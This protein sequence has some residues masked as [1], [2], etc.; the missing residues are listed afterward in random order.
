MAK[1]KPSL[2][3]RTPYS[4]PSEGRTTKTGR[5]ATKGRASKTRRVATKGRATNTGRVAK[6]GRRKETR[7]TGPYSP[8]FLQHLLDHSV[9]PAFYHRP[10]KAAK[11]EENRKNPRRD[12]PVKAA[13]LEEI[14][15]KLRRHRPSLSAERFNTSDFENFFYKNKDALSEAAVLSSVFPVIA[16]STSDFIARG[17]NLVFGNLSQLTDGSLANCKPDLYDGSRPA[18]LNVPV[19]RKLDKYIIPSSYK[20]RPCLPN[21]IFEAEGPDGSM[22]VN[23]NQVLYEG[24]LGA[25]AMHHLRLYGDSTTPYDDK[26]YTITSTY[27]SAC[28]HLDVYA[29]HPACPEDS[30]NQVQYRQTL[31]DSWCITKNPDSFRQGVAA[32][33]NAREWAKEQRDELIE[34]ANNVPLHSAGEDTDVEPDEPMEDSF[35]EWEVSADEDTDPESYPYCNCRIRRCRRPPPEQMSTAT[36]PRDPEERQDS[37]EPNREAGEAPTRTSI[38][39]WI[40]IFLSSVH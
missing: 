26:A 5:V 28:G 36:T 25:R 14:R 29:H 4:N 31:L 34:A 22:L 24:A 35:E 3:I 16:G 1:E 27:F 20:S 39:D 23:E 11:R 13:N 9:Y 40:G 32:F 6:N 21:F 10:V 12:R 18:E 33:R 8:A 17:Q 15:E 7:K 2:R 38:R 30:T 37:E 19:R